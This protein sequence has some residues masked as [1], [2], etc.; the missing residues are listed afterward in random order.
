MILKK[1]S[2]LLHKILFSI[3]V[4]CISLQSFATDPSTVKWKSGQVIGVSEVNSDPTTIIFELGTGS[5]Y[6][7]V[8]VVYVE[9]P[10]VQGDLNNVFVY[11][12]SPPNVQKTKLTDFLQRASTDSKSKPEFTLIEL[13]K[14]L[15]SDEVKKLNGFMEEAI[16]K[17]VPYNFSMEINPNTYNCSE[18]VM[19]S[20][21]SAGIKVGEIEKFSDQNINALQGQLMN[22]YNGAKDPNMKVI[23]PVSVMNSNGFQAVAA[24]LPLGKIIS[25]KEVADAWTHAG[26]MGGV[27]DALGL[28]SS[29]QEQIAQLA[30]SEPY[31]AFPSSW[32]K[33]AQ[34]CPKNL[35]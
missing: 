31:R 23:T 27:I 14:E 10:A 17:K 12:A 29:M 35:K 2:T 30:S 24:D 18:F 21:E 20:F 33:L 11:E 1:K 8:G 34:P 25:E 7:H 28:P 26:A 22:I 9:G 16:K 6:G 4:L 5:R 3:G 32:G 19:R 15:T 13:K